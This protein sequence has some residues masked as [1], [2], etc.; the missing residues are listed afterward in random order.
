MYILV[1]NVPTKAKI[2]LE[3]LV[4][5]KKV[6]KALSWLKENN[7][8]YSE[9][10]LPQ[11][12]KNL[13]NIDLEDTEYQEEETDDYLYETENDITKKESAKKYY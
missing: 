8:L 12:H 4:D 10:K 6:Y 9:I 2:V 11:N 1:C 3:K 5:L 7:V 13:W